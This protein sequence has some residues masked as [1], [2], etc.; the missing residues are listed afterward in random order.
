MSFFAERDRPRP[1]GNQEE[2]EHEQENTELAGGAAPQPAE[3]SDL[4]TPGIE[5][6]ML[7]S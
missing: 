6:K 2:Q 4:L 1:T 3:I 5:K 7:S